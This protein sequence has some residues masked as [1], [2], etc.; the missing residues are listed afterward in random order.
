MAEN[1]C[2][3]ATSIVL[4]QRPDGHTVLCTWGCGRTVDYVEVDGITREVAVAA[5][6]AKAPA[7]KPGQLT[8]T[9]VQSN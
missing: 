3:H 4:K 5:T 7:R 1:R 6:H 8:G 9:D 2:D